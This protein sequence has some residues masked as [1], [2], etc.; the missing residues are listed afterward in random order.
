MDLSAGDFEL[1]SEVVYL[2][3]ESDVFL[4][5]GI[6][7]KSEKKKKKSFQPLHDFLSTSLKQRICLQFIAKLLLQ[8]N[9]RGR[10]LILD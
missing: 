10:F 1:S 7:V 9:K 5:E 6:S 2:F 8:S 4:Q 3:N